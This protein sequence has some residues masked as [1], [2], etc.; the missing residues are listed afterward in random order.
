MCL[1]FVLLRA[2]DQ[3]RLGASKEEADVSG[4]K[5]AIL[6]RLNDEADAEADFECETTN[7]LIVSQLQL[8]VVWQD[9]SIH[10]LQLW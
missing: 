10:R 9:A 5:R 3:A 6:Q 1:S 7:L 8:I 2:I 4:I